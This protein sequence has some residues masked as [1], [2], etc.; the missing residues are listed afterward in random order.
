MPS[1]LDTQR[2]YYV[3]APFTLKYHEYEPKCLI[4]RVVLGVD[5]AKGTEAAVRHGATKGAPE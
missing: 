2:V 5:F 4:E 1:T 3:A